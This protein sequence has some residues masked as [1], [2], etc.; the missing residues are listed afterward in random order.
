MIL[1]ID[2]LKTNCQRLYFFG[3]GFIQIKINDSERFHFYTDEFPR[4][5][6]IE[7]IHNHRYNFE[8]TI[9]KGTIIQE[10]FSYQLHDQGESLITK[11]TCNP[12]IKKEFEKHRCRVKLL[13]R[14]TF[15]TGSSYW[16]DHD[17]LHRVESNDAIT[18]LKRSPYMKD[19]ADVVYPVSQ[20]TTCPFSVKVS[21]DE[22][23]EV[24][25]SM[26]ESK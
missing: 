14:Q 12:D 25:R 2:F 22:L 26:I 24:V 16:T 5:T 6:M 13:Q 8:S 11:E 20:V 19:E 7:E 1:N 4:T 15:S 3:L 9:M 18:Y 10:I 23:W 17:T 21:D